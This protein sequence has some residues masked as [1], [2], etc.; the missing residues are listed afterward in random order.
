[1]GKLSISEKHQLRIAR[2]TLK[3]TDVGAFIMG[4]PSKDEARRII[5]DLTGKSAHED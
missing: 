3:M 1:M 4:P 5:L 2:K